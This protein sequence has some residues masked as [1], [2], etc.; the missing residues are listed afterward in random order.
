MHYPCVLPTAGI[1]ENTDWVDRTLDWGIK[2]ALYRRWVGGSEPWE[3]LRQST[4][5]WTRVRRR[6]VTAMSKSGEPRP[7]VDLGVI[8]SDASPIP[9][10]VAMLT[11][12]LRRWGK[13]WDDVRR[14]LDLRG[15]LYEIDVRFGELGERGIFEQLV[16]RG[17]LHARIVPVPD[18]ERAHT[19]PPGMSRAKVR[20]TLVKS[21][22]ASDGGGDYAC[23]RE[24]IWN[25]RNGRWADLADPFETDVRWREVD[26][27]VRETP[28]AFRQRAMMDFF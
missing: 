21:M 8:L 11:R 14:F 24:R 1:A 10:E 9:G 28:P 22:H 20:G 23:G 4:Q 17:Q 5:L 2:R 6:F 27:S 25:L 26:E 19:D 16:A 3:R 18:I 15:R 7:P 13:D 12:L